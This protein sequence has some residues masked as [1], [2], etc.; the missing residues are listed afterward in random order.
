MQA[1]CLDEPWRTVHFLLPLVWPP[2]GIGGGVLAVAGP[3]RPP[4]R[5]HDHGL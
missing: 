5:R 3:L 1:I 4:P 2:S